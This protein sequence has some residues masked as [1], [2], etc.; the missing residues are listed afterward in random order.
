M[1]NLFSLPQVTYKKS[2]TSHVNSLIVRWY[3]NKETRPRSA[4]LFRP[5]SVNNNN[6]NKLNWFIHN[7]KKL[8]I[9][10]TNPYAQLCEKQYHTEYY[11]SFKECCDIQQLTTSNILC[12]DLIQLKIY[13]LTLTRQKK[14]ELLQ[15]IYS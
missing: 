3:P 7:F 6:N 15:K 4:R 9:Y 5:I 8:I 12:H 13:S 11:K 2:Q 1:H 10:L 14:E